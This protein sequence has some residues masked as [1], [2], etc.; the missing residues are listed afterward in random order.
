MICKLCYNII[1]RLLIKCGDSMLTIYDPL[2][3][4]FV[5]NLFC[6]I[7]VGIT[8]ITSKSNFKNS[9]AQKVFVIALSVLLFMILM[10]TLYA[11]IDMGRIKKI[12]VEVAYLIKNLYFICGLLSGYFW[13]IYFEMTIKSKFSETGKSI[14][15]S[16]ILVLVGVILLL[17]NRYTNFMFRITIKDNGAIIYER[18]STLWFA[19]FYLCIYVYVFFSSARCFIFARKKE[20]YVEKQKFAFVGVI[21]STPIVFGILQLVFSRLPI[22]C[23]GLTL[24]IFILY[25]YATKDQVSNDNLTDLLNRKRALRGIERSIKS[26]PDENTLYVVFMVDVNNFKS[27]N[28]KY[29]HLEGDKALISTAD[30]LT[31]VSTMQ[32]RK[33]I[34]GRF[35]GDEFLIGA[36]LDFESEIDIIKEQINSELKIA[37]ESKEYE[38]V[39]SIG[40]AIYSNELNSIKDLI[41]EADKRLYEQKLLIEENEKF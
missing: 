23:A 4:Y 36:H 33:M 25:V 6:F 5:L 29:G 7:I 26:K 20:H 24:S 8:I 28:D 17:I 32:K 3:L 12:T 18:T 14:L 40:Y 22:V 9:N 30:A 38:L 1:T 35:G 19:I 11:A 41:E 13:F 10:D 21:A 15:Y 27:I 37:S 16:S 2:I 39:A 31:K 34:V